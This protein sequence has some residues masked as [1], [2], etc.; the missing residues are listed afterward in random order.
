MNSMTVRRV[1]EQ[2]ETVE[3]EVASPT[4]ILKVWVLE[5]DSDCMYECLHG[6]FLFSQA[7]PLAGVGGTT[8]F[9]FHERRVYGPQQAASCMAFYGNE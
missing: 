6:V 4:T 9:F 7:I 5:L 1:T 8:A 2:T 3:N